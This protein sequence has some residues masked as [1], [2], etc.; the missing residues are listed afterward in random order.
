MKTN[1]GNVTPQ[2]ARKTALIVA[3]VL[4]AASALFWYRDKLTSAIVSLTLAVPSVPG[5]LLG[6]MMGGM[7]TSDVARLKQVLENV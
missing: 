7:L 2:Q 5:I 4:A 3:G 6:A 1:T